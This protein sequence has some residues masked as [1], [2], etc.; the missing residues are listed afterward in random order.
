MQRTVPTAATVRVFAEQQ[1]ERNL[2]GW[3]GRFRG[4]GGWSLDWR[5]VATWSWG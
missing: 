1:E 2:V 5:K 4:P 3:V